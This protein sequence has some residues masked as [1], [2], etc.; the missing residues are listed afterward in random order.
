[1]IRSGS[2]TII[3]DPNW[4]KIP[5]SNPQHCWKEFYSPFKENLIMVLLTYAKISF[6]K[7]DTR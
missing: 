6:N 2:G 1:M 7:N 5:V 4:Q 3:P